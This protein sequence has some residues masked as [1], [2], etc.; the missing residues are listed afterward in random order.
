MVSGNV[1]EHLAARLDRLAPL[2]LPH[3]GF[4]DPRHRAHAVDD[5]L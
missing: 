5:P 2:A 4:T 1:A 3:L